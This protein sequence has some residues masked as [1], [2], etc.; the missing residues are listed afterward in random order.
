M[1]DNEKQKND[2]SEIEL[3][4]DANINYGNRKIRTQDESNE[5]ELPIYSVD[6]PEK[7]KLKS[8]KPKIN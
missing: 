6:R 7:I 4:R 8:N 5:F 2:H 3:P 1:K